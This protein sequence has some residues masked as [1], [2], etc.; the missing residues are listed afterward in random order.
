MNEKIDDEQ[1]TS[2][3]NQEEKRN[4]NSIL[5]KNKNE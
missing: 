3:E 4:H 1:K 5:E 2:K